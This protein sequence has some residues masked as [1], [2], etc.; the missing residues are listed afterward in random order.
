MEKRNLPLILIFIIILS[1]FSSCLKEEN[2]VPIVET[3]Q[4]H[5]ITG[6]TGDMR[7]IISYDNSIPIPNRTGFYWGTDPNPRKMEHIV[8]SEFHNFSAGFTYILTDLNPNTTY[9]F[10]AF[11]ENKNGTG[12]GNVMSF[13]TNEEV[14]SFIIISGEV[15][16]AAHAIAAFVRYT[17]NISFYDALTQE[18]GLCIAEGK[19][20]DLNDDC[21]T[22]IDSWHMFRD[23][24]GSTSYYLRAYAI[25]KDERVVYS[26]PKVVKTREIY[27]DSIGNINFRSAVTDFSIDFTDHVG[28]I[29]LRWHTNP[30]PAWGEGTWFIG[31]GPYLMW[32]LEPGTTY[33]ARPFIYSLLYQGYFSSRTIYGPYKTFTTPPMPDIGQGTFHDPYTTNGAIYLRTSD[34]SVWVKGYIVGVQKSGY[35]YPNSGINNAGPFSDNWHILLAEDPDEVFMGNTLRVLLPEG[36][37]Q[38]N[39]NLVHNPENLGKEIMVKGL[40]YRYDN[41]STFTGIRDVSGFEFIDD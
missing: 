3:L 8:S 4:A 38:D 19:I 37:I 16:Y 39:L 25:L 33:Y 40:L 28:Y 27:M 36:E 13:A 17:G 18:R 31:G 9:Y 23:L 35:L 5:M 12:Y 41:H 32:N 26:S 7:G 6:T 2:Q 14:N 11:A 15:P 24:K 21:V 29:G 1:L 22:L 30:N 10:R 20:P 34:E